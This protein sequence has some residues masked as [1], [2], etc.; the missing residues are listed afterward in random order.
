[1]YA[2]FAECG[3]CVSRATSPFPKRAVIYERAPKALPGS[4][5]L[6]HAYLRERLDHARPHPISHTAYASLNNTFE[7]ALATMNKMPRVWALY[8][9]SLLD[10]RLLTRGRRAFDRALRALPVTQHD[11]IWPL[12]LRLASLH[13]CPVETS[14]RVFRRYLQFDPSH[15][16]D[17][18]EFLV[19]SN[20][21]QEAADRLASVLNDDGFRS[22]KGK[23]RHQLWLELCDILTKHA[24]EVA[25]LKVDAILRGG[26]RKFTD[27]VGKLWTSLADYY[28]RRTLYEKARDVFEE[29]VAS[30]MTVQEFSVVFEAYTQFE[31]SMLAAKLEAAEEDGGEGSDEDDR[32]SGM[33]KLSKKFLAGCWLT[34]EDDTDLRL[35]RFERLLDRRPELLSSVLLRQNPHNVEEWHR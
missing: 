23:T 10:Q 13:A 7:R 3:A 16:E 15:A 12:Y 5:K 29:G 19:S 1:L 17:F 22:V 20:R 14:F 25:G 21:W 11:R 4:Y 33:D 32:K 8:L 31:Q 30:V 2:T 6:W 9:A 27:E 34:D 35:A 24:D 28:V 26:I 18:I